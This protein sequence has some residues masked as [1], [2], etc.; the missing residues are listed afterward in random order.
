MLTGIRPRHHCLTAKKRIAVRDLAVLGFMLVLVP[1]A[2]SH[3]YLAYLL[4]CWAG[5]VS[6]NSYLYGPMAGV[7]Y[8][9][10]FAL[11]GLV[12]LF[13]SKDKHRLKWEP[14]STSIVFIFIMLHGLLSATF[15]YPGLDRNWELYTNVAKTL[16]FCL[17]MPMLASN[18]LRLYA[19]VLVI[20]L[21]LGFHGVLEGLKFVASGGAHLTKG[22]QKFGDNNHFAM[23]LVM[24]LPLILYVYKY[25][26]NKIV[27]VGCIT[28]FCIICLAVISTNSRGG[29]LGLVAVAL[30]LVMHSKRKVLGIL[31]ILFVASVMLA[32]APQ[33]WTSR[34]ESIKEA[35]QDSSFMGR[36]TAWKRASAIAVENPI[37]GGG[38]H[39]GQAPSIYYQFRDKPGI[40]GFI[41]TPPSYYPAATHSIY[42]EILGDLGFLGL[43]LFL[44][45]LIISYRNFKKIQALTQE[46]AIELAWANDLS[47]ALM[48]ALL[49]FMVCGAALSAAYFE[50]P[51]ILIMLMEALK[52]QVLR[53]LNLTAQRKVL[54]A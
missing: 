43:F 33:S 40:L 11:I 31:S 23:V 27:R 29:L 28:S 9:Q 35:E 45:S 34:M 47:V 3:A 16:L 2:F 5:L 12:L 10:V 32:M 41:D 51:Y 22:I 46:K 6:L 48:A 44:A 37:L 7:P 13:V 38:Y 52:Q 4:W 24:V 49:A 26:I 54:R 42:F 30:F 1:L 19:L 8:V 53:D 50:I 17:L 15:A 36:V 20:I 18:R 39:A 21:S 14:N 25:A